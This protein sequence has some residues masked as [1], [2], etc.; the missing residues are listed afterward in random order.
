MYFTYHIFLNTFTSL[1]QVI[2]FHCLLFAVFQDDELREELNQA[3]D[4]RQ[5]LEVKREELVRRAKMLQQKTQGR[6]NQG[7]TYYSQ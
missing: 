5:D 3:R 2:L 4:E 7:S 6:R 1:Q